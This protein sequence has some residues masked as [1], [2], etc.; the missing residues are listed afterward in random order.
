MVST[1]TVRP[2]DAI[3][4]RVS[5]SGSTGL[6][7]VAIQ[8]FTTGQHFAKSSSVSSASRSSAEFI[9]EA[10]LVCRLFRCHLASLSN[11]GTVGFGQDNTN[12][13]IS[14]NC[15]LQMK[16]GQLSPIGAFGSSVQQI[17]MVSSSNPT[18]VKAQPSTLSTD[19]T[20]FTVQWL[21]AGP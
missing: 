18:V 15:A 16:G 8:D 11:F 1:L 21:S 6:F 7:T 5:Y 13:A 3:G 4:A 10:P 19:G 17:T 9:V 20:S 14:L 2:G 12:L